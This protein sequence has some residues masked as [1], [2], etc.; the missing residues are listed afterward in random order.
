MRIRIDGK[1]LEYPVKKGEKTTVKYSENGEVL[2]EFTIGLSAAGEEDYKIYED[3]ARFEGKELDITCGKPELLNGIKQTNVKGAAIGEKTRPEL[4]FTA[5]QG[6]INDPNGLSFYNGFYHMF[7]QHNPYGDEWGNMHWG[8]AVSKDLINWKDLGDI[9][10]PDNLNATIFSGSAVYD[11]NNT[12]GLGSKENP[13]HILIYTLA[14]DKNGFTQNIAFSSDG[15]SYVKYSGNPVIKNLAPGNRDPKVIW[16]DET[17]KWIMALYLEGEEFALFSSPDLIVWN[18]LQRIKIPGGNE[19][20]DYF[21]LRTPEGVIKW[22]LT[23]AG[24]EYLTGSFDGIK[25]TPES[26]PKKFTDRSAQIRP[27]AAQTFSDEPYGRRIITFWENVSI[28]GASFTS[29]MSLP[30]EMYFVRD[31]NGLRLAVRP[32]KEF[33]DRLEKC[34]KETEGPLYIEADLKTPVEIYGV[35]L[36]K[37]DGKIYLGDKYFA[38]ADDKVNMVIDRHSIELYTDCNTGFGL[39]ENCFRE[40]KGAVTGNV[41]IYKINQAVTKL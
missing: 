22:I 34:G 28:P 26:E 30:N 1:Y 35:M 4:H 14:D 38:A 41:Q 9:L 33:Y 32:V 29:Q 24:T 27:Y 17:K 7:Y 2:H 31:E 12:S 36:E 19:C 6:W 3:V 8:H 39:F 21:P 25:F 11:S 20:P 23:E 37:H 10:Y 40:L 13:P 15:I 16:Y 5:P 18:E